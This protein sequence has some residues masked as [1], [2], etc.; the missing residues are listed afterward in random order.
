[1]KKSI[2]G[3]LLLLAATQGSLSAQTETGPSHDFS[4][5]Y[6]MVSGTQVIKG[7]NHSV[8]TDQAY[9]FAYNLQ[10]S[11]TGNIFAT[12]KYC[13]GKI[14][15][16][17]LTAGYQAFSYDR[18]SDNHGGPSV[19]VD[20]HSA[21]VVTFAAELNIFYYTA[22]NIQLYGM[23]GVGQRTYSETGG[24]STYTE[25][26]P[27]NFINT[28]W[29]PIGLRFG[30]TLGGYVEFGFGYKGIINTG[31]SYRLTTP[32]KDTEHKDHSHSSKR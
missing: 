10:T 17:G 25:V 30:R 32:K 2:F 24:S 22:E 15:S 19:I 16:I 4:L 7:L 9:H 13:P 11:N 18:Y 23:L 14:L 8:K 29:T 5:S 21:T 20:H 26:F 6:G 12:Y 3:L 27:R 28:Q 31:I 1:M